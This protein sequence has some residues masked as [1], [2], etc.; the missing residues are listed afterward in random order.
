MFVLG[1]LLKASHSAAR[2]SAYSHVQTRGSDSG[3]SHSPSASLTTLGIVFFVKK[4]GGGQRVM[5]LVQKRRE[6]EREREREGGGGGLGR[7]TLPE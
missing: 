6:R 1:L 5:G 3:F 7:R 2:A 4:R